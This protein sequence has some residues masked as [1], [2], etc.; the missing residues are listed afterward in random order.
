MVKFP[1]RIRWPADLRFQD[2]RSRDKLGTLKYMLAQKSVNRKK[3]VQ[4]SFNLP[5]FN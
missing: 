4:T 5:L 1:V 2:Y 3:I